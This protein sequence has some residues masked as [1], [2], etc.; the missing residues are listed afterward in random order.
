MG[1]TLSESTA[2][3][4]LAL[5]A[6]FDRVG[7]TLGGGFGGGGRGAQILQLPPPRFGKL[8]GW[9]DLHDYQKADF[10]AWTW[11]ADAEEWSEGGEDDVVK[12]V[13]AAP[14]LD[15]GDADSDDAVRH[16]L[17]EGTWGK[18]E[19]VPEIK[20]WMLTQVFAPAWTWAKLTEDLNYAGNA[21][22]EP[23]LRANNLWTASG[24][25]I[26]VHAPP[27][28]KTGKILSGKLVRI[29]WLPAGASGEAAWV[30]TAAEC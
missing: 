24:R 4:L 7:R 2:A 19:F 30:V 25:E 21:T 6:E 12:D 27:L 10:Q 1:V 26:L 20:G 28:L 14:W 23:S 16:L 8:K 13:R 5:L 29:E 22:A 3:R 18:I 15:A 9:L 11:D 17:V